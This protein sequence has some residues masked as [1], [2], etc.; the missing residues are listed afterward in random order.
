MSQHNDKGEPPESARRHPCLDTKLVHRDNVEAN[1]YN[2]NQVPDPELDLLEQSIRA[3]DMTMGIVTYRRDDG[4][5]E[6]V[7]GFHR[8]LVL[9]ERIGDE[10]VPVSVIDKDVDERMSST[11]RHNRARGDHT[12]QLMGDLVSAMEDEGMSTQEVA[13]ELG[14]EKEEVVRLKQ[15]I[16]ASSIL[17]SDE[18]GQ[19]WGVQDGGE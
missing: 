9:T 6:I 10:W 11:V 19:S 12:T 4:T 2:P 17:A 1:D 18:Y 14:M 7:D 8:F 5:Y 3:D 13:E 15:V 16:G